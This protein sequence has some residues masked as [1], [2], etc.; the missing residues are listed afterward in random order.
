MTDKEMTEYYRT[1]FGS[2]AGQVVLGDLLYQIGALGFNRGDV[3]NNI[4]AIII[5][6]TGFVGEWDEA[7]KRPTPEACRKIAGRLIKVE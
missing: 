2:S 6:R 7:A 1:V 5:K 3:A 4:A